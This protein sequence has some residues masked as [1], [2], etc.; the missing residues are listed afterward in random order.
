MDCQIVC[1]KCMHEHGRI[2]DINHLIETLSSSRP[3]F[4]I[5]IKPEPKTILQKFYNLF[6]C[7]YC[8]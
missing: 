3:T 5:K 2:G 7:C 8:K 1:D 6:K 4:Y